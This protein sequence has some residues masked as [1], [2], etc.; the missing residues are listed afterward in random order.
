[1]EHPRELFV[2]ELGDILYAE[3]TLVKTLPV[4]AEEASDSTL[5]SAFEKHLAETKEQVSNLEAAF[6]TIGETPKAE[7]CP[8]IDGLKAEHDQFVSKE[9]PSPAV[10][11]MFLTG[12]GA[13]PS[14]TRSLRTRGS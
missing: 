13:E 10:M 2:H 4:L 6:R 9:S 3:R 1:M 14:T 8:G 11:D 7:R 12:A 5:T